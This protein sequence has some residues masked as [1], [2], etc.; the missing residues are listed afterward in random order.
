MALI[1]VAFAAAACTGVDRPDTIF[2]PTTVGVIASIE[3][4][5]DMRFAI[6][7]DDGTRLEVDL[8]AGTYEP[9]SRTPNPG[10]LFV[11]VEDVG[12]EPWVLVLSGQADCFMIQ[13][14]A[15]DEGGHLIFESGLR[16]PKAADYDAGYLGSF[17]GYTSD[18][19]HFC[20]NSLGVVT[21]FAGSPG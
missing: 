8:S 17:E 11:Y 6:E 9:A 3:G 4:I 15:L 10:D 18:Q 19:A 5:R 12:G 2:E 14:Q 21:H 7:L 16:L 13:G 20:I 1:V